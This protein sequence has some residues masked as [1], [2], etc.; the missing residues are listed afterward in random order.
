MLSPLKLIVGQR[1]WQGLAGLVTIAVIAS[2]LSNEQQGW[3]YTF[4][5]IAALY[6][7]FELGLSAALLQLSAHMFVNLHW[8]GRGRIAGEGA[9]RFQSFISSSFRM[10]LFMA[11][12]FS[13][14]AFLIGA[15]LFSQRQTTGE[16]IFIWMA[17]WAALVILTGVNMLSLPFLAIVEGTGEIYEVYKVRLI[18]GLIGAPL[19]WLVLIFGGWL[20]A[21]MMSPLV[22]VL[23]I[24]CWLTYKRFNL[25]STAIKTAAG[26]EFDW[27]STIWPHQWRL[28]L[29]WASIFLM[30]QLATPILF[31]YQGPV[32]AGQMG[33]S[34]TLAHM[35][36][37][38]SQSWITRDV[39][40]MSRAAAKREWTI[41]HHIFMRAFTHSLLA[42]LLGATSLIAVFLL[43]TDTVYINRFLPFWEFIG[44]IAF[45]FFY[46]ISFALAAQ[47]RSFRREPLFWV[48]VVGALLVVPGSIAQAHS[49]SSGVILVMLLTQ[50]LFV[51]PL[52]FILWRHY[53]RLWT[54]S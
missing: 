35:I 41:L 6:S 26:N 10:Y 29:H 11:L 44:L 7:L 18:Q 42:F 49:T 38:L 50:A 54:N 39:P 1:L 28:G 22:A 37:I 47:L 46:H 34:L 12:L 5:S 36:G 33:L 32:I 30:S 14:S 27:R 45:V 40:V 51:L 17:P 25:I 48:S 20:W 24:C 19:T 2:T 9:S 4:I 31:Y 16:S 23:V 43:L 52:S 8:L 21:A 13:V 53:N 3:Y 15:Y